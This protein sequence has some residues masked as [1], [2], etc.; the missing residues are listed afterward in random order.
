[1]TSP[2]TINLEELS[3][4][5]DGELEAQ[6]AAEIAKRIA[7]DPALARRVE[8]YQTDKAHLA[9]HYEPLLG[10]PLPPAWLARLSL[11]SNRP[12]RSPWRR[13]L[14]ALAASVVLVLAGWGAYQAVLSVNGDAVIDQAIAA[15]AGTLG[16]ASNAPADAAAVSAA[17][18]VRVKLPDL[19]RAGY[20]LAQTTLITEGRGRSVRLDYRDADDRVFTL[21]LKPSS[22]RTRF[23]LAT[24]GPLRICLWQDDVLATVMVGEMSGAEMLRV[25]SLAYN[26]LYF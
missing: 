26:G 12:A 2:E 9:A 17:L 22:G 20:R 16:M 15:R 24:R 11:A 25:A 19:A 4:F 21:Y 8:A 10:R 7:A 6:R 1:M 3:A 13:P 14:M 5:V 18:G 23:E